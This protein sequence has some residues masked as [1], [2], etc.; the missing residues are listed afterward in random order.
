MGAHNLIWYKVVLVKWAF[1][2]WRA[3]LGG[4][5]VDQCIQRKGIHMASRCNCCSNPSVETI[6]HVLVISE[7]AK[8]VWADMEDRMGINVS[9]SL[10]QLKLSA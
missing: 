8:K 6:D 4:I 10:L 7:V 5:L 3:C 9:S 2:A 1:F